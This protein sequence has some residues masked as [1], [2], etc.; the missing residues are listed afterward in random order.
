MAHAY[1]PG[2]KVIPCTLL[3]KKRV[4]PIP[5]KVLV[6]LGKEVEAS[7][8]VAQTE[9][10]GKVFPVNVANRLSVQ[11]DEIKNFMVKGEGDAITSIEPASSSTSLCLLHP[12]TA[13]APLLNHR[14][15]RLRWA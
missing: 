12:L 5:G 8:I 14:Q 10:P 6:D 11:P 2:L 13:A 15:M 4:L 7:D 3:K 9:L 1:T